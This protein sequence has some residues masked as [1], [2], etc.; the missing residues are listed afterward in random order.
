MVH[1]AKLSALMAVG[2]ALS[3]VRADIDD[4]NNHA[5][6][7]KPKPSLTNKVNYYTTFYVADSQEASLRSP[8]KL[9]TPT[10]YLL[11]LPFFSYRTFAPPRIVSSQL[12]GSLTTWMLKLTHAKIFSNSPRVIRSI[13]DVSLGKGPKAA[14]GDVAAQSNIKKIQDY[15]TSCM[16]EAAILKAGRKPVADVI[17]KIL[18]SLPDGGS[19]LDKMALSKTMG[20]LSKM[21]M[22]IFVNLY[23]IPDSANPLV[24]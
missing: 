5:T 21:K 16:D 4:L 3:V 9:L 17:Q 8:A 20:Q 14:P 7:P 24:N 22:D 10:L 23:V 11:P 2:V 19:G 15:F 12:M 1:V 6:N 13:V 18:K